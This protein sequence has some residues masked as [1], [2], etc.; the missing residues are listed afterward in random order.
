[1]FR[2]QQ[3]VIPL[4]IGAEHLSAKWGK[5]DPRGIYDCSVW[6]CRMLQDK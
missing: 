5:C 4:G 3:L 6:F 2:D 1:M